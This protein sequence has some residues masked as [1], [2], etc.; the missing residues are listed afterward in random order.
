MEFVIV[1]V[2]L[3]VLNLAVAVFGADSR[4]GNDWVNHDAA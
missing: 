4:D 2:V 3:L 1:L